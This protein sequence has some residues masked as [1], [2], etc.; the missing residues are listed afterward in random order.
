MTEDISIIEEN[1]EGVRD[2]EP[3][4]SPEEAPEAGS[5]AVPD[6][7]KEE[8]A[9]LSPKESLIAL[10]LSEREA[11]LVLRD[12]EE[13]AGKRAIPDRLP[14]TQHAPKSNISYGELLEMREVFSELSD[15][16]INRL[17]NKVTRQERN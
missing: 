5:E 16:E 8:T 4:E 6:E 2:S 14:R 3:I 9:E 17:Y 13:G 1:E 15:T 10:G 11:E 12:R 7:P